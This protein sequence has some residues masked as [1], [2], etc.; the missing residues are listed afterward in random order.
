MTSYCNTVPTPEGG[1]H[2]AGLRN[3][4]SRG[5]KAY[6]ELVGNRRAA[7]VTAED[8]AGGAWGVLSVFV[9]N[10][11]FQGQTKEKLTT[12]SVTRLVENS[13][14]DHFDHFLSG[15]PTT[16]NLLL[17]RII[18]LAE[19]RLRRTERLRTAGAALVDQRLHVRSPRAP[20]TR[21][22]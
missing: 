5:I 10:P 16:A 14:K 20:A 21:S 3:A 11:E 7:I 8:I 18:E 1:T 2:E 17:D 22:S 9:P 4:L 12:V 6:A 15:D 13:V 19:D